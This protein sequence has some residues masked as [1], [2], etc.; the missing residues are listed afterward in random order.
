MF[1]HIERGKKIAL[2]N[3]PFYKSGFFCTFRKCTNDTRIPRLL[4]KKGYY[5]RYMTWPNHKKLLQKRTSCHPKGGRGDGTFFLPPNTPFFPHIQ[6]VFGAPEKKE[7]KTF[8]PPFV[9]RPDDSFLPPF[10]GGKPKPPF[11]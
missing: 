8:L 1:S 5:H 3:F 4:Y 9:C 10:L 2:G 7:K 11:S 6:T